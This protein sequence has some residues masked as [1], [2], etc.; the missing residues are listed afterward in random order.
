MSEL[1]TKDQFLARCA[2]AWDMGL[3][4]PERLALL[5]EWVDAILRFEGGQT[6]NWAQFIAQEMD[7]NGRRPTSVGGFG[8]LAGDEDGYALVQLTALLAHHCQDC[9]VDPHAWHTR[10]AF[11]PHRKEGHNGL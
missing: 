1:L 5:R 2:N 3:C 6:Y 9:A 4:T 11:C 8:A 10:G 7:R